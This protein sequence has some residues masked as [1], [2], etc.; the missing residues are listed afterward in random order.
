MLIGYA[1]PYS[2]DPNSKKQHKLLKNAN[3]D[4]IINESHF[5]SKERQNLRKLIKKLRSG[6]TVV[7]AKLF[8][9]ADSTRHLVELL[10]EIEEKGAYFHSL[11]EGINT[12]N[13]QN[14]SFKEIVIHIIE[15]ESDLLS[16]K[17]KE[18][19]HEAKQKGILPGRPRIPDENVKKAIAMY[20]SKK[21]S[22][23]EIKNETGISKSTLYRYLGK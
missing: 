13:D 6:D 20:E 1:R 5:S 23:A 18:G 7:V 21:Y 15:F 17:T 16:E 11:K 9:F 3:C 19:I 22:L 12:R 4:L 2:S 10:H 14:S 8:T